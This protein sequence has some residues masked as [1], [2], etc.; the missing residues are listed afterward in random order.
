MSPRSRRPHSLSNPDTGHPSPTSDVDDRSGHSANGFETSAQL[1]AQL[2]HT[3]AGNNEP[4]CFHPTDPAIQNPPRNSAA[5]LIQETPEWEAARDAVLSRMVTSHDLDAAP[6]PTPILK[7]KRGGVKTGGRRG[8]GGRRP[9]VKIEG[10]DGVTVEMAAIAGVKVDST[11]T[12]GKNKGGRP[13]GSRAG[14]SSRGGITRP[15]IVDPTTSTPK[16]KNKGG[17]P[18]GSKTVN[19]GGR[20]RGSRAGSSAA[21]LLGHMAKK[22]RKRSSD[23]DEDEDDTDASEEFIPLAITSSGR[24][25]NPTQTYSPKIL[26]QSTSGRKS[27]QNTPT[28]A[29]P[30][31]S[32]QNPKKRRKPGEAAVCINCGRGHSPNSNQI[33]FCDGCNTPWHQFC[34]DRP[35]TP[36][37]IQ[38]EEKEWICSDCGVIREEKA[39]IANKVRAEKMTLAEK[40]TYLKSLEKNE[41]VSLLLHASTLHEDLPIFRPAPLAPVPIIVEPQPMRPGHPPQLEEEESYE[42]YIEPEP[43]P[44]PKPGNGI[45]LPPEDDDLSLLIDEDIVTYSHLWKGFHGWEGPRGM[46]WLNGDNSHGTGSFP[47][48]VGA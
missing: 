33:V 20:P 46:P 25:I 13:R 40:R 47:I 19:R 38:F 48:V 5:S 18:R 32:T 39:H 15:A 42:V 44:Y 17:R 28:S 41:L 3:V 31:I 2:A 11:P 21:G 29:P 1:G 36:T 26:E 27:N 23:D 16:E 22:K 7:V 45:V 37:V 30:T 35:I 4:I 9:K 10:D 24:R 12:R 43:L 8:R 14:V 6:T 34:H